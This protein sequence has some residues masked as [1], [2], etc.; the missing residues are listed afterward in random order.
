M[1][2]SPTPPGLSIV[3]AV[4]SSIRSRAARKALEWRARY[5]T[6]SAPAPPPAAVERDLDEP[7]AEFW[8]RRID[9][10][11][12][13]SYA[14][15]PLAKFPEDLRVYQHLLWESRADTVIEAGTKWGGSMLWFRDQLRTFAGYGRLGREPQ[16]IGVD[17]ATG[18]ARTLLSEPTRTGRSRSP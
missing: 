3:A 4:D 6:K 14:G 7:F 8:R 2:S 17:L 16:V 10:H 9:Q 5:G 13:D 1:P 12:E 18:P 15:V 11:N